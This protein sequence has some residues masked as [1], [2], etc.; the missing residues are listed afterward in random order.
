MRIAISGTHGCGKSTLIEEFLLAHSDFSHEPEAYQALQEEHGE[1]F[2]AEPA[3]EDF[4]RQLEYN[5]GRL[6][7]Y[8]LNDRVIFERCPVDYLAYLFALA[9]L[10]RDHDA[11]RL[12]SAATKTVENAISLL[13]MI[14]FLPATKLTVA[15]DQ[16]GGRRKWQGAGGGAKRLRSAVNVRLESLLVDDDLG[17]FSSGRPLVIEASGPTEQRLHKLETALLLK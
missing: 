7:Q 9:E 15:E 1:S 8:Q 10:G 11:S 3:A 12:L 6:N 5:I 16:T 14:V 17:L 2:A 4:L 13:D